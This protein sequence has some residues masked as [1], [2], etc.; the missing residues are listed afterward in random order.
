MDGALTAA[1]WNFR[2]LKWCNR[3]CTVEPPEKAFHLP[4]RV[5]CI[6]IIVRGLRSDCALP[7]NPAHATSAYHCCEKGAEAVR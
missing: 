5:K 7:P 1:M 6:R 4:L 3:S 2:G